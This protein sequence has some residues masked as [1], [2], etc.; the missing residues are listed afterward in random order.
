[1][2]KKIF[3]L[4]LMTSLALNIAFAASWAGSQFAG[5]FESRQVET[6]QP[7]PEKEIW[8]PLHRKL[9]VTKEQ[10]LEIEPQLKE[11]Q[12]QASLL[13]NELK[14]ARDQMIELL[15]DEQTD[16]QKVEQQQR[17]ILAGHRKMQDLVLE[18]IIAEKAVLN[19]AQQS[20]FFE[21]LRNNIQCPGPMKVPS[22]AKGGMGTFL[23][24]LP[25]EDANK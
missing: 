12:K 25:Q 17:K 6:W 24:S 1:M 21:I 10:W 4:I 8:C 20:A 23:R 14:D 7:D 13:A 5:R 9:S 19:K 2:D 18:H 11:F 3:I 16:K 15:E 22:G